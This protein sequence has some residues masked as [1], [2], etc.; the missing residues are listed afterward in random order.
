MAKFLDRRKAVSYIADIIDEAKKELVLISPYLWLS[1]DL[2]EK[3]VRADKQ[4]VKIE[5]VYRDEDKFKPDQLKR[6]QKEIEKL[7]P[8][9]NLQISCLKYLHA[10]CYYNE[11]S[12]LITSMN[13]YDYSEKNDWEMGLLLESE[14]DGEVFNEAKKGAE[15]IISAA[16]SHHIEKRRESLLNKVVKIGKSLTESLTEEEPKGRC[17]RCGKP[18]KTYDEQQPLCDRCYRIWARHGDQYYPEKFCHRCGKEAV[19]SKARPLCDSCYYE[20][21]RER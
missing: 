1:G 3:L 9:K 21:Q 6:L 17:I 11:H 10:K 12:M 8:L 18:T 14:E 19:T 5:V 7:Q 16:V 15:E 20:S 2:I 4:S 13:L